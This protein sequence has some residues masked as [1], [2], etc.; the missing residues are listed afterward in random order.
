VQTLSHLDTYR[1]SDSNQNPYLNTYSNSDP[2]QNP[3]HCTVVNSVTRAYGDSIL[4]SSSCT[5]I[6]KNT[7]S[8]SERNPKLHSHFDSTT[9]KHPCSRETHSSTHRNFYPGVP[10]GYPNEHWHTKSAEHLPQQ[11]SHRERT[12]Y[13]RVVH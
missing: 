7:N 3:Y 4:N 1:E 13:H 9:N 12:S 2:N 5:D 8:K 10:Q 11:E 6:H